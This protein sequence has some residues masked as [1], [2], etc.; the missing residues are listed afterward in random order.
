[1]RVALAAAA[2]FVLLGFLLI[3]YAGIEDDEAFFTTAIYGPLNPHFRIVVFHHTIPLMIWPYAG[4]LK[5]WLYRPILALFGPSAWSF[6]GPVVLAGAATILLLFRFASH[7]ANRR[8][9][10]FAC[11]LLAS[12]PSF[13]LT[14]TYDWGPV[15]MEHLLLMT[16]C[17]L[18]VAR[19]PV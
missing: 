11:L 19:R 18:F 2:L 13:L 6:R 7:L 5:A 12:D 17:V 3:P 1:M 14:N 16:G 4:A 8:A 9:A 10:V 15:A